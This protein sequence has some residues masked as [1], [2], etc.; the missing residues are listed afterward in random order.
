MKILH[1]ADWHLGHSLYNY[2]RAEE[3]RAMLRQLRE[4]AVD[5]RPDALLVSGDVFDT[6]QPSAA[7]QRM[8]SD[9]LAE[10]HSVLP[11]MP[12]IVT[13]GNHDSP[14][15]HEVFAAPWSILGVTM[16]G[17]LPADPS[18]LVIEL[19]GKGFIAAIPDFST[20]R[21]DAAEIYAAV[22]EEIKRRN[23]EQLPVVFMGHI[24]VD[25]C[26]FAGHRMPAD[27][28][29]GGMETVGPETF[30]TYADYVALGHI[31]RP[32]TLAGGRIRY[33]GA[34]L[35]VSFEESYPHSVS[36]VEI[37]RHGAMPRI[38]EIEIA[39][40][41]PLVSLPT[42]GFAGW[43]EALKLLASFPADIP[44]YIRLNV[45]IEDSLPINPYEKAFDAAADKAL[46]FCF[47]NTR[48]V[49]KNVDDAKPT[50]LTVDEFG[51]I[52]PIEMARKKMG[53]TMSADFE[54]M[55][56]EVCEIIEEEDR[57]DEI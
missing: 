43:E 26:S 3:Q 8:L 55:F 44:A 30:G 7:V 31:H 32:Q 41:R 2:N 28:T 19:E 50:A 57:N 51:R 23:T 21:R 22:T 13:A 35:A 38:S 49:Q 52:D 20:R 53:G 45:E 14:S 54:Q 37:D 34:P 17:V 39:N 1:T 40:P 10:I 16:A 47:I 36:L 29:I 56:R 18:S 48:R 5:E 15:R 12:V 9:A 42:R 46:R 24:S 6:A 4:I 25:G 33:S 27:P 11:Q